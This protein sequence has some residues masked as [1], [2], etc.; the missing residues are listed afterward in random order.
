MSLFVALV[1]IVGFFASGEI[2]RSME[3]GEKHFRTIV[4]MATSMNY[5]IKAAESHVM[6]YLVLH[7]PD[8]KA[9][10][11]VW[12]ERLDQLIADVEEEVAIKEAKDIV[13]TIR[14]ESTQFRSF[15]KALFEL[16]EA[17]M[18][19][20][21]SFRMEEHANQIRRLN[22]SASLIREQAIKLARFETDFLNRQAVITAAT[23]ASSYVKRAEGHLLLYLTLHN[24]AD[25]DKF[26]KRQAAIGDQISVLQDRIETDEGKQRLRTIVDKT[27]EF[28]AAG[29]ALIDYYDEDM[30]TSGAFD[31]VRR[32]GTLRAFHDAAQIVAESC[33]HLA[34]LN[35]TLEQKLKDTA[36]ER[37]TAYRRIILGVIMASFI[38]SLILGYLSVQTISKPIL[39]LSEAVAEIGGG[40][41]DR[42]ITSMPKDEIGQ[43]AGTFNRMVDDLRRSRDEVV[44]ARDFLDSIITSITS[45]LIVLSKEGSIRSVNEETCTMLG[46]DE[47]ELIGK[48]LKIIFPREASFRAITIELCDI[49]S[50]RGCIRNR[51]TYYRTRDG[52]NINVVISASPIPGPTGE[53][54]GIVCVAQDMTERKQAEDDLREREEQFR[55]TFDYGPSGMAMAGLD[56]RLLRVNKAFCSIVGYSTDELLSKTFGEIT[57]PDDLALN[58]AMNEKLIRGEITHHEIEKR[59]IRKDGSAVSTILGVA[60]LRDNIGAPR[61]FIAQVIDISERKMAEEALERSDRQTKL[62]IDS[63]GEGIYGVGCDGRTTFINH[64][65]AEMLGFAAD[66][67]IGREIHDLIHHHRSDGT[68][69]P[70]ELCPMI[71]AIC[72]G[73]SRRVSDERFW[74]KD[75]SSFPVDYLSA[76]IREK[77]GRIVGSVVVFVDITERKRLEDELIR[78]RKLES[79]GVL[80]GGIAHDFNN[81]ITGVLNCLNLIKRPDTNP[82]EAQQA[83]TMAVDAA[84]QASSLTQQ[85]FSFTRIGEPAKKTMSIVNLIRDAVRLSLSSSPMTCN[86]IV[87]D[88]LWPVDVDEIQMSRVIHNLVINAA[89]SMPDGGTVTV[90]AENDN[91]VRQHSSSDWEGRHVVITVEDQ[92]KGIPEE[93]LEKIFDPYFSTKKRGDRRGMGLG[94]AICYSIVRNHDGFMTVASKVGEGTKV[95]VHLRASSAV[96]PDRETAVSSL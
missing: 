24:P 91:D 39:R 66:E 51:E 45:S 31:V 23:D 69:Y 16:Y 77:D 29:K 63:V 76:P 60:L 22:G 38:L 65:A 4:S 62:L 44:S 48:P 43:L 73:K 12:Q 34:T 54:Q 20:K 49:L 21:G 85:L 33:V 3:G 67:I 6:L 80:A 35:V 46:Y 8:D 95:S 28:A 32:A 47:E 74:R 14:K 18:K 15:S 84:R 52:R 30:K 88:D 58:V 79:I 81:L 64:A 56:G 72:D 42:K 71:R 10:H 70:R 19:K 9:E 17:D 13:A 87:P 75:G 2:I 50:G 53:I 25:K 27:E 11:A 57:H 5:T 68:P 61:Y 83:M 7:D 36:I 90:R 40:N 93:H 41:L 55:M 1:G 94:L 92:G 96:A 86:L 78:A 89:E 26:L 82:E 37:A 59:Y